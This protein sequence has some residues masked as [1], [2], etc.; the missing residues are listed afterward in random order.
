MPRSIAAAQ[1]T[2]VTRYN[3]EI[4]YWELPFCFEN[5]HKEQC[6]L[7]HTHND[8]LV[9]HVYSENGSIPWRLVL[10]SRRNYSAITPRAMLWSTNYFVGGWLNFW[11]FLAY[12]PA[13]NVLSWK[14]SYI[15][16][17]FFS[18][19]TSLLNKWASRV[20]ARKHIQSSRM[21]GWMAEE[22][23][24]CRGDWVEIQ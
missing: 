22:L 9:P 24:A 21:D 17:F 3:T 23:L 1:L 5:D 14:R 12:L 16:I 15:G 6:D 4:M 20:M 2:Y 13:L 11:F 8:R 7:R 18:S 19:G 10:F